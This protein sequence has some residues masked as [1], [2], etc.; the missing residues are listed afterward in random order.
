MYN[1]GYFKIDKKKIKE[2]IELLNLDK[3]DIKS[4][5]RNLKMTKDT[6]KL[7][8]MQLSK[9]IS[10]DPLLIASYSDEFDGVLIYEYPSELV[11]KY[12]LKINQVLVS[13]NSYWPKDAFDIEEDISPGKDCSYEWRDVISF[14]PLF[15]CLEKQEVSYWV[16][17]DRLYNEELLKHIDELIVDYFSKKPNQVRKGFKTLIKY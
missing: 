7:G 12:N 11:F 15:L 3:D 14:I 8:D 5:K 2:I 4:L 10:V 9:V 13:S 17:V 16:Y 1:P 6:L